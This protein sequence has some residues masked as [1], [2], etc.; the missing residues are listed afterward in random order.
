MATKISAGMKLFRKHRMPTE[1]AAELIELEI[2]AI[3]Q[4]AARLELPPAIT[5]MW[6]LQQVLVYAMLLATV[7]AC[8]WLSWATL[9]A[10]CRCLCCRRRAKQQP[11]KGATGKAKAS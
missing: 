6:E 5:L 9:S 8:G 11:S 4:G 7:A 10:C 3:R 1:T 2:E